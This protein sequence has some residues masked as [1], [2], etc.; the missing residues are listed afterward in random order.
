VSLSESEDCG[1][2][3]EVSCA[4]FRETTLA[5][6]DFL[7]QS[8]N[9]M[10]EVDAQKLLVDLRRRID[11]CSVRSDFLQL[12]RLAAMAARLQGFL[13]EQARL[14]TAMEQL[15]LEVAASCG[16]PVNV[17]VPHE[18]DE[19]QPN[20]A[21]RTEIILPVDQPPIVMEI[22][23]RAAGGNA[24]SE[25]VA[26]VNASST[27]RYF[28]GRVLVVMGETRFR[29]LEQIN[30]GR[31]PLVTKQPLADF[32]IHTSG[33]LYTHH[34]I[35]NSPWHVITHSSTSEK[36]EY[37]RRAIALLDLRETRLSAGFDRGVP[38]VLADDHPPDEGRI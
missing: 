35:A 38:P 16:T 26:H 31:G 20:V 6:A 4:H 30:T 9:V 27:L 10:T 34:R 24:D 17:S 5:K 3:E 21:P 37:L 11:E 32:V 1:N 28:V 13:E 8:S 2:K 25:I 23:W 33:R 18:A 7:S 12:G 29:C 14:S 19:R 36:I 15:R 22:N